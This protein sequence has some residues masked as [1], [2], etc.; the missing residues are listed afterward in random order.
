MAAPSNAVRKTITVLFADLGGSTGFGE[1][2]DAEV[3]RQV[4]ARYHAL[5]QAVVDD[6]RGTVAKFMGD[7]MMASFGIPEVAEDDAARAVAAGVALQERFAAFAADVVHR[8]GETLTLRVGINTGEVVIGEG[9][10]DLVGD[11]LNVAARLE[12]ACRPGQVLVGEATWRLTRGDV[13]YEVLGEITVAGRAKPVAIYEVATGTM[14]AP[15]VAAPFVGRANELQRLVDVFHDARGMARAQLVTVLGSPGVGKTRLS[16]ELSV[17]LAEHDAVSFE[18]RC[19]RASDATFAPVAQ[20]IRYATGIGDA[21]D[22]ADAQRAIGAVLPDAEPDRDRVISVLAGLIGV[23]PARSVEET[24]WGVRR[25]I[26]ATAATRPLVIV[27]DDIQWAEPLLLDLIEHLTEWV[28]EATVLLVALARPELRE[29]RPSLAEP[30]RPVAAVVVLDGLDPSDTAALAAGLLGAERLPVDLAERLPASTEGNPLFVR[31][32]VR[33]LVDD[34]VIRRRDD[35]EW[36]L[37]IDAEAVDVPPTIQ[38]LLG[39][40]IERL[41]V[42]ERELLEHASVVGAE[43]SRGALRE[44]AG[45]RAP[46]ASL[47]ERMRR[48]EL[49]EPTGTYS[50]DEPVYRFH[51]VLIRD[52][53]YRRLLKTTRA[54][55]HER[56]ATWADRA[57]ADRVGE[58]E[59]ATAFH[60]EQAFQYR[61]D[62]GSRDDHTDAI[63]RRGAELL[64]IAAQHALGRDDLG[65]AGSLSARALA[66]L[67]ASATTARSD[68]LQLACECLLASGDGVAARPL[69]EELGRDA[70]G[71]RR[72][73]AWADCYAAQLVGLTDPDALVTADA[74]VEAAAATLT[75]LDDGSGQAKAHQVRAGLLARL[76]RVGD[77]EIELDLALAAARATGDRRRVTAVLGTAPD[78][79]LFGPSPVARAGGR[80]LDVVRLL[81]IT[82][83]SPSV[84]AA[85]NRCQAVL[86]A[87]RGR[88]DVSRSMLASARTVLEELGLRHG[89]AQTELFAGMVEMIAG[90]PHAAIEPLRAALRGLG[91]LGVGADAGTAA[92]LLARAL[93]TDGSIDEAD[94]MAAASERLAGQNLK[95]AIAWRVAR[96]EVLAA[97][98]DYAS[99]VALAEQAVGIAASTDLLIDHADAC[100]ALAAIYAESGDTINAQRAK[101]DAR[102][103][104]EAKGATAPLVHLVAPS[105]GE[106]VAAMPFAGPTAVRTDMPAGSHPS[107]LENAV[108]RAFAVILGLATRRQFD[109]LVSVVASDFERVDNRTGVAAPTARGPEAWINAWQSSIE[110]GLDQ[111]A[112]EPVAIR[113]ERLALGYLRFASAGGAEIPMLAV[114]EVDASGLLTY[115]AWHNEGATDTALDELD[116]RYRATRDATSSA[117]PLGAEPR[118]I[119]S[120]RVENAATRLGHLG[121]ECIVTGRLD[122]LGELLADDF[123]RHD[124]R[125][126]VSAADAN[127]DEYLASARV[128]V[129]VGFSAIWNEPIAIRGER[130]ALS[131]APHRSTDGAEMVFVSLTELDERGRLLRQDQ[132]DEDDLATALAELDAR[133]LA[134]EGAKHARVLCTALAVLAAGRARDVD[135]LDALLAPDFVVVDHQSIGIGAGDRDHL[136]ALTLASKDIKAPTQSLIRTVYVAGNA[137]LG[138][139]EWSILSAQ[140][141]HYANSNSALLCV[142]SNDQISRLEWF[143]K[144]DWDTALARLDE[145]GTE[146]FGTRSPPP[147]NAATALSTR[148]LELSQARRFDEARRLLR[149]D[150]VR[151]D[152][153]SHLAYPPIYSADEYM[154]WHAQSF[155]QFDSITSEPIAV[156]GERLA[157]SK[158]A[159]I[160]DGGFA[161]AFLMVSE[162][163]DDGL[164]VSLAIYDET[165]LDAAV[166]ELDDR[167]IARFDELSGTSA[168]QRTPRTSQ[169]ENR[170]T[171]LMDQFPGLARAGRFASIADLIAHDYVRID[172][173]QGIPAPTSHGPADFVAML[174]ATLD[175]GFDEILNTPLAVRGEW[176]AL[177]RVDVRA[178]DGREIVFLQVHEWLASKLAYVAHYEE[179]DLAAAVAELDARYLASEGTLTPRSLLRLGDPR[180]ASALTN[181][182]VRQQTRTMD[183]LR[184]DGVDAHAA[185]LSVDYVND[186]RRPTVNTDRSVGREPIV[187]LVRGLLDVGFTDVEQVPVAI[188]GERLALFRR[189]WVNPDGFDLEVLAIVGI[190]DEHQPCLNVLFDPED[191]VGALGE[192]D[193]SYIAEL[194]PTEAYSMRRAL[195]YKRA[196]SAGNVEAVVDLLHLDVVRVDHRR[197]GYGTVGR[198]EAASAMRAVF[199]VSRSNQMVY[200]SVDLDGD[201]RLT[202]ALV[203]TTTAEGSRYE[204][205]VLSV[206]TSELGLIT[207]LEY[208]D[209]GDLPRA[210]TR[211][212]ELAA[213]RYTPTADNG[214]ARL[215]RRMGWLV[216]HGDIEAAGQ[217]LSDDVVQIDR[218]R[219]V[220]APELVGRAARMAN[221]AAAADVIGAIS[222]EVTAVRGER[223]C[224]IRWRVTSPDGFA[225]HGYDV[226]ETDDDGVI[227]RM[228]T[229]DD[230]Q[231]A[232]AIEELESRHAAISGDAYTDV[233]RAVAATEMLLNS[234]GVERYTEWV[235]PDVQIVD[236]GP[237]PFPPATRIEQNIALLREMLDMTPDTMVIGR[238]RYV[239]S[240]AVLLSH[241]QVSTTSEGNEYRWVRFLVGVVSSRGRIARLE[242]FPDDRWDD[243]VARF[244]QLTAGSRTEKGVA[245][246][247]RPER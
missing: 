227:R 155:E 107:S 12:K 56:I 178:P 1:R 233:E 237:L 138:V 87:L 67:P 236:H 25:L 230:T 204:T 9:D 166:T 174:Q 110:I 117:E 225:I 128:I 132:Y 244:E 59:A 92:A 130:L 199:D 201:V 44:L 89:L 210:R 137:V 238:K 123:V 30:G 51:H 145:L 200:L 77:A 37:T 63:A 52:A 209:V 193:A 48:K 240:N 73:A 28:T 198:E 226:N 189:W 133:Y 180:A 147:E 68:L 196:F 100:A 167:F 84:E 192:L 165:D 127:R 80:C 129:E 144:D 93:L 41:P 39:A 140:G 94:E 112:F 66:L 102:R 139:A 216:A 194:G 78:A 221:L 126:G 111:V 14:S 157:L 197:I 215:L 239:Q 23:G 245:G 186:D 231:L 151:L 4:L 150:L 206:S 7:G 43:F 21:A 27:I 57:G 131:R 71:D 83:A 109:E 99:A 24:F 70:V 19:D 60:Y 179:D 122:E 98:A 235:E 163:D 202:R 42:D 33:M 58:H 160:V 195:D 229:F 234:G 106:V 113:G 53:A 217:C 10:A 2:A 11:A 136:L 182:A 172:H 213:I 108:T 34:R 62:L 154:A 46:I 105:D 47:L 75:E 212:N 232:E 82:T 241:E 36:E 219:G 246:S 114:I 148:W 134:G 247:S 191:L 183:V 214:A 168:D 22:S 223:T 104:Y 156:R 185:T 115:A 76:G 175:V 61:V 40:R 143:G 45:E 31:E 188:R 220:A 207:R 159:L 90:E 65:A 121:C 222:H 142:D 177:S 81:R 32:L 169:A 88:F 79:A 101:S 184:A 218:R 55:L 15:E 187:K 124:H 103:L 118:D 3:S 116:M 49:V 26:E 91:A 64:T 72:L 161:S 17:R 20:L 86:E 141:S 203:F 96:A 176:L 146:S 38:S 69:V 8:H 125:S 162:F 95:T 211:F 243:A 6:H 181:E 97:R 16:R 152:H 50:G 173:R 135:A 18:L 119:R 29:V 190:N 242:Y 149:S 158:T 120:P 208:F 170:A 164:C 54:D 228:V 85:S 205:E 224:L 13:A 153:R 35:G 74:S 171:H 5:L